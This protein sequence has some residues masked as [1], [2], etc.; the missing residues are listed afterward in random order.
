[1]FR[2]SAAVSVL[3]IAIVWAVLAALLAFSDAALTVD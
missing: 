2:R 3:V 1:V